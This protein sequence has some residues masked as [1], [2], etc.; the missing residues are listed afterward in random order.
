MHTV[1]SQNICSLSFFWN[2][3]VIKKINNQDHVGKNLSKDNSLEVYVVISQKNLSC[4]FFDKKT[5]KKQNEQKS[6]ELTVCN[7]LIG[8]PK[9]YHY[10]KKG[11]KP[12]KCGYF[13]T[14]PKKLLA[15]RRPCRD[16]TKSALLIIWYMKFI[17]M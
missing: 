6:W 11:K 16:E 9:F 5:D 12:I 13:M 3:K 1:S 10:Q 8:P 7:G 2:Q 4:T 15:F 17:I 14:G